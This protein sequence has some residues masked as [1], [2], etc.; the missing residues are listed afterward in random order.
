MLDVRRLIL[1]HHLVL[2]TSVILPS[3]AS[4]G[5]GPNISDILWM[6]GPRTQVDVV[7]LL[8][9]SQGVGQHNFLYFVHPF[10]ES[11]LGQYA[12]LH[13][14]YARSAVVTFARDATVDY[15]AISGGSNAAV[16]KCELFNSPTLWERVAF[17]RDPILMRGTNISGALQHAIGILDAGRVNRPNATQV[18]PKP[19]LSQ[20]Q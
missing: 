3:S 2:C 17:V 6:L 11:L 4:A 1:L 7:G 10:F 14:D 12:T 5:T 9:R 13:G 18:Q 20:I 16:S 15:D 19:G 8:D